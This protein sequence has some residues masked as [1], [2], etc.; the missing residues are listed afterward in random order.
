MPIFV[1]ALKFRFLQHLADK[2]K[3]KL[4]YWKGK[5]FR[6]MGVIQLVNTVITGFLVYSFNMFKWFVSLLK[7]VEQWCRN[8]FGVVIL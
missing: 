1:G 6:I 3:L 5:S 8:L 4:A 7:Q 2:V